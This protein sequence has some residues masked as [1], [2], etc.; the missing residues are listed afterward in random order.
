LGR[1]Q[2]LK[3]CKGHVIQSLMRALSDGIVRDT[4]QTQKNNGTAWNFTVGGPSVGVIVPRS[5]QK[6]NVVEEGP[7]GK[8]GD[9][10]QKSAKAH[11]ADSGGAD[12]RTFVRG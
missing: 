6:N 11:R 2:V 7:P 5:V 12:T 4:V 1:V 3:A 10:L 9:T 8:G